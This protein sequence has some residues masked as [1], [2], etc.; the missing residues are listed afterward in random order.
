MIPIMK[1]EF[2]D[3]FKSVRSILIILFM[4]FISYRSAILI[5]D[6]S[7]LVS[8]LL[9]MDLGGMKIQAIVIMFVF[10]TL[11]F[12]FV[13]AVSHDVVNK[14]LEL[15]TIR[16]LVTKVSRIEIIIGKLLGVFL[17]WVFVISISFGLIFFITGEFDLRGYLETNVFA[18]YIVSLL[19]F[20]STIVTK[21]KMTMFLAILLGISLPIL[22]LVADIVDKWYLL[23][24]KYV[25]PYH[26]MDLE[27]ILLAAIVPLLIAIGYII[28]SV[29]VMERRDF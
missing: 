26:Y 4:T 1:R 18:F 19:I 5:Q 27:T 6:N 7:Y 16:L 13:F 10:I 12:L 3:A 20:I 25:L 11:G 23:P 17:F 28:I 8:S 29:I 2:V 21:P 9:E 14:E 24:F 22:G 15:K